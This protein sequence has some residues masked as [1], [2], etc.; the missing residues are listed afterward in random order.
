MVETTDHVTKLLNLRALA[1]SVNERY[2]DQSVNAKC[3]IFLDEL[4]I[5]KQSRLL[6]KITTGQVN[7]ETWKNHRIRRITS[8][9]VGAVLQKIDD[10]LNVGNETSAEN[11]VIDLMQYKPPFKSKATQWGLNKEPLARKAYE[12]G[13]KKDHSHF[14]VSAH[15]LIVTRLL[16]K[17]QKHLEL[18]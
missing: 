7:N 3:K 10:K 17:L 11:L 2:V 18:A 15:G 6:S 9:K 12:Y 4:H 5:S 16:R 1:A 8:S 13:C 14:S